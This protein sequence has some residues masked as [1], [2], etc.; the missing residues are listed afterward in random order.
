M[1]FH[2][3]SGCWTAWPLQGSYRNWSAW[4]EASASGLAGRR[5]VGRLLAAWGAGAGLEVSHMQVGRAVLRFIQDLTAAV[6]CLRG[7]KLVR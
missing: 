2:M 5:A 1:R 7:M 3:V 6:A 4:S